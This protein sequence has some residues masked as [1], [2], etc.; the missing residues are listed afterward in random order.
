MTI[1][2]SPVRSLRGIVARLPLGRA[3]A[4]DDASGIAPSED[5]P[6]TS[7]C[8]AC[9]RPLEALTGVCAGC[10]ARLVL[11]VQA[12]RAGAFVGAGLVAGLLAG[13]LVTGVLV[14]GAPRSIVAPTASGGEGPAPAGGTGDVP[15]AAV[16]ATATSV[17][18]QTAAINARLVTTLA[19]LRATLAAKPYDPS[20][21]AQGLRDIAADATVAAGSVPALGR[22]AGAARVQAALADFYDGVLAT[23]RT[24][25]AYSLSDAAAYR[26]AASDMVARF[27]GLVAIDAAARTLAATAGVSLPVVYP[28]R[29]AASTTP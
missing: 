1:D 12:R 11:G 3:T 18:Q 23:A 6:D 28:G 20:A 26:K 8:P 4:G 10:G 7:S 16:P 29:A 24:G 13:S 25:L 22:W 15:A 21:T 5:I 17:L 14:G 19:E 9:G 27:K 2:M